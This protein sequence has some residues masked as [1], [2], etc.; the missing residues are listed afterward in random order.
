MPSLPPAREILIS[1]ELG[2]KGMRQMGKAR[3]CVVGLAV[4][5]GHISGE[6]AAHGVEPAGQLND[7]WRLKQPSLPRDAEACLEVE[8]RAPRIRVGQPLFLRGVRGVALGNA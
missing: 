4:Q 6:Q 7:G 5:I 3:G 1:E 8:E 2:S